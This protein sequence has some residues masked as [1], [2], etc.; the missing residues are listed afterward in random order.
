MRRV[1]LSRLQPG[2]ELAGTI[3]IPSSQDGVLYKL[4]LEEGTELTDNHIDRL[5]RLN[6]GK[7]PIKD[8]DTDDLDPFVYDEEVEEAT[9]EV[10]Q[11]F[12]NFQSD[13]KDNEVGAREI[14]RLRS[15]VDDLIDSLRNSQLMA[16]F[17]NLKTH[18]NYT[19]EHSL[20]VAKITL[21]LVLN[22][23]ELYRKK[24]KND[25]GASNR[26]INRNML[27]D[28]GLGAMLHDLGK[29]EVPQRIINKSG[30]LSDE[31]W[32]KME[33]HPTEGFEK[34]RTINNLI[35]APVR[36]PAHQHHEKYD[37]SGYPRGLEGSDIHLFGRI[38]APADVYSALTSNRPYRNPVSPAKGVSILKEMQ[39][40]G[41]HFDP[42]IFDDFLQL[43]FPYPVGEEVVL[44]DGRKGVV[45]DVDPEIPEE[46]VVRVLYEREKRLDKPKEIRVPNNPGGLR[47]V[48]PSRET[49]GLVRTR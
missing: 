24:L 23:E 11:E 20:D 27:P 29:E 3:K 1:S 49:A 31:E 7:V 13:F 6:I 18:D 42:E 8:S 28:L 35:N 30:E 33:A 47:I 46:P 15:A 4:R 12:N 44:S 34:L 40:G 38:L 22:N 43:V 48:K 5:T 32:E 16:A 2:A 25:S 19:A 36:V 39:D 10:R 21:Q 14:G 41:P 9:E 17:T 26:Y 45:C 37:G